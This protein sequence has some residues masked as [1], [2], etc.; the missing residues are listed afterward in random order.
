MHAMTT[1]YF[2]ELFTKDPE[3]DY[4]GILD[5]INASVS[6]EMNEEL[7]KAFSDDEISNAL[8]QIGPLKAPGVDGF[9]TRFYQRNWQIMREEITKAVRPFFETGEMPADVNTTAIVLIPEVDQPRTLKDY[10]PISLCSVLYKIV[11]KCLVNRLRPI[12][13]ELISP[14]QSAFVPGRLITDN[15]LLAFECMH[16]IETDTAAGDSFCAY[17]LDLSKAYDRVDWGYLECTMQK[18]GFAP[19]D[20][21]EAEQVLDIIH[22]YERGTGQLINPAKCSMFFGKSCPEETKHEMRNTLQVV[23]V[24]FESKYL[25]LPTPEGRVNR[26]G[27]E[28][29]IKAVAQALPTYVMGV[30]KLPFSVC[31]DLT[32]MTRNYWWGAEN[33]KQK[34]HWMAWDK[35]I[36]PKRQ[37]GI[38]FRDMRIF[39]QTLLARQAW[40]L[41]ENPNSLCAQVLK[42]NTIHM[43][44]SLMLSSR[45]APRRR[46]NPLHMG[47]SY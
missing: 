19:A 18:M 7:C 32:Q 21:A 1:N 14:N 41:I 44:I 11:A 30:F 39:N 24:D 9:P 47:L 36:R 13:G 33:G 12:L 28:V 8:F 5:L 29:L 43:G 2:Q 15:A 6:D 26:R 20:N 22:R 45:G 23:E 40:W 34:T 25:G 42:A 3:I 38:G 37:G 27:K 46:G 31:E 17:K 10:R 4:T 16:S 35:M